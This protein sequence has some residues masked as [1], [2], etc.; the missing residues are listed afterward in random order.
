MRRKI[1]QQ[2]TL[3]AF[4]FFQTGVAFSA[5]SESQ[6]NE[7]ISFFDNVATLDEK[8]GKIGL[9]FPEF[10]IKNKDD[11]EEKVPSHILQMEEINNFNNLPQY[12]YATNSIARL[13]WLAFGYTPMLITEADSF[14]EKATIVPSL[15]YQS[16]KNLQITNLRIMEK[17][18]GQ[19]T[20]FLK[21]AKF[22]SYIKSVV[23]ANGTNF[24]SMQQGDNIVFS[25][26]MINVSVPAF[27]SKIIME[28]AV[29]SS[30]KKIPSF[31][32]KMSNNFT[33]NNIKFNIPMLA[34]DIVYDLSSKMLLTTNK[35]KNTIDIVSRL[36]LKN[37]KLKSML[38]TDNA[39]Q[40]AEFKLVIKGIDNNILQE[41]QNIEEYTADSG[42]EGQQDVTQKLQTAF[43]GRDIKYRL[44]LLFS[45]GSI[46][47]VGKI[48]I[49]KDD[50]STI[51][52]ITIA[53]FAAIAP[54]TA[55]ACQ[56]EMAKNTGSFP[57][58]CT[59]PD[60]LGFLRPYIDMAKRTQ[61]DKGQTIDKFIIEH[62]ALGLRVNG[63]LLLPPQSQIPQ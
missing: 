59:K 11:T 3:I 15:N 22:V 26:S 46:N 5:V 13:K 17:E 18:N 45:D 8:D 29:L 10:T 36:D 30:S 33:A 44:V 38:S 25:S 61:N 31:A 12:K 56:E 40:S 23:T 55:K 54:D 24:I 51:S 39:L 57:E 2:F 34:M 48:N 52:E 35:Q 28:N 49:K 20:D 9:T 19:T 47:G 14:I 53:N 58:I 32:D 7:I 43:V 4:I 21:V 62:S 63:H 42:Q 50:I 60:L 37:I 6:K 41:L 27:V 16:G 1:I